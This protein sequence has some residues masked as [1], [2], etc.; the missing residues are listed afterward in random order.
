MSWTKLSSANDVNAARW[1]WLLLQLVSDSFQ[2]CEFLIYLKHIANDGL[3]KFLAIRN[4]A[5]P[6]VASSSSQGPSML[7]P[8][9]IKVVRYHSLVID[10]ISLP[11]ELIPLAWTCST[12][13]CSSSITELLDVEILLMFH[14]ES[15]ATCH[16]S[17]IFKNFREITEDFLGRKDSW[18]NRGMKLQYK[19]A[20]FCQSSGFGYMSCVI[21]CVL[22]LSSGNRSWQFND[23]L[24]SSYNGGKLKIYLVK[25]AGKISLA[26]SM[27]EKLETPLA[28]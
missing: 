16:G 24:R 4:P 20:T 17:Q 8:D 3:L 7:M 19:D 28:G 5:D 10:P 1:P 21:C 2:D 14:P 23:N 11:K 25:L 13:I 6:L 27:G 15:I 9:I 12:E 26:T 22:A 18:S